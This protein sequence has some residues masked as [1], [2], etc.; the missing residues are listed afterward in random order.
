[1]ADLPQD[2]TKEFVLIDGAGVNE[3]TVSAAGALK[4]DNSAVTQ[5]I[6][7]VDNTGT[8]TLTAAAQTIVANCVGCSTVTWQMSGIFVMT[9][10]FEGS[11]D[12]TNWIVSGYQGLTLGIGEVK[13]PCGGY[14]QV[15]I[16]CTAYTSGTLTA[17]WYSG[18]GVD[19]VMP[20]LPTGSALPISASALPLPTGAATSANQSTEIASLS[21]IDTKVATAANQS[22]MISSLSSIDAGTPA[23][24]GQTTMSASMPVAIASDQSVIPATLG[25][26]TGKAN[27]LKTGTLVTT[28]TTADQVV[29]TYTVT[30]AKTFY[31][32]YLS[33]D[34]SLTAAPT[35]FNTPVVFGSISMETPSGTKDITWRFM[36]PNPQQDH[37][38]FS[39]PV[40]V[41][42]GVVIRVVVTPGIATSL[43][44]IA[45][46][47]GYER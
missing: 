30:A 9:Y 43:T 39:E 35:N 12:G 41:A 11:T 15:R 23:A 38:T 19:L 20:V 26:T 14:K 47:G 5:P 22:T 37:I 3:A 36:G 42:A 29:L 2:E 46:F 45:N 33:I 25:N 8:G 27:V 17:T 6:V 34:C 44:W 13:I 21:S 24:L 10:T 16:R 31:L 18:L 28:A 1:M 4:V 40:P 7:P 32:E